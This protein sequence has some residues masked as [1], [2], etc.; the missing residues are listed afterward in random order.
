M[1]FKTW[2]DAAKFCEKTFGSYVD[3][4]D[5]YFLC[6]ECGEPI[7]CDDWLNHNWRICPVCET[8][9]EEIE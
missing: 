4:E 9:F 6:P 5:E 7:F 3:W 1:K 2:E 8:N